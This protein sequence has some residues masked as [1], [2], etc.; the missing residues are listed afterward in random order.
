[1]ALNNKVLCLEVVAFLINVSRL[2]KFLPGSQRNLHLFSFTY[3]FPIQLRK[4]R[5]FH[6]S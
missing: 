2:D 5:F 1:M 4:M 3:L 6:L